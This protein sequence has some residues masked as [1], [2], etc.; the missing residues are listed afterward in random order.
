MSGDTSTT[1]EGGAVP[2]KTIV[3]T[4][5]AAP[6]LAFAPLIAVFVLPKVLSFFGR[7]VGW[8]L[9]RRTDGRRSHLMA[10]MTE[11][12]GKVRGTYRDESEG[13]SAVQLQFDVDEKT[14]AALEAQKNWSGIVGF[15]HPFWYVSARP[16]GIVTDR[17]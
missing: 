5:V 9:R 12:D 8:I 4:L 15:F 13:G 14:Q 7:F 10:Y 3:Q 6:I 16:S 2:V 11:E 1:P 17:E